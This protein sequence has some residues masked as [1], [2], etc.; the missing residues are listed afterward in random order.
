[1]S[2]STDIEM[3]ENNRYGQPLMSLVLA[4]KPPSEVLKLNKTEACLLNDVDKEWPKVL[5]E[6]EKVLRSV[7]PLLVIS[8]HM[9]MLFSVRFP[10]VVR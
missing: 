8:S 1:M 4:A 9:D 2:S 3:I 7:M 5:A 10:F 6:N